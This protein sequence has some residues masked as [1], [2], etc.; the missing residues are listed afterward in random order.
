MQTEKQSIANSQVAITENLPFVRF[1]NN[2]EI[3]FGQDFRFWKGLPEDVDFFPIEETAN[4][5]MMFVGDG[6]GILP[7]HKITGRYGSG[8][9]YVFKCDMSDELI[10]WCRENFLQIYRKS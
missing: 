10:E 7:E 2:N 5:L 1:S 9:I 4:E 6:Y 3:R 8:A